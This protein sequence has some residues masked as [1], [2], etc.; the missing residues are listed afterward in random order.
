MEEL[1]VGLFRVFVNLLER[2]AKVGVELFALLVLVHL[3]KRHHG[4]GL[5]LWRSG[6]STL[7]ATTAGR[8]HTQS[9]TIPPSNSGPV[10]RKPRQ[11]KRAERT[12]TQIRSEP[13]G[14]DMLRG[15]G[16]SEVPPVQ[17]AILAVVREG[18]E[19]LVHLFD[20]PYNLSQGLKQP[21]N[22]PLGALV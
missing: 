17:H 21:T 15:R 20:C 4:L 10:A 11:V 18:T 5:I 1:V 2:R 6:R 12:N 14:D 19:P 9:N 13:A 3:D 7:G 22:L 8:R 16:L